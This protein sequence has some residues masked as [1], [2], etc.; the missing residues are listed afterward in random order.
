MST[1]PD[2]QFDGHT[3]TWVVP[4]AEG[5]NQQLSDASKWKTTSDVLGAADR[6]AAKGALK[7]TPDNWKPDTN[8]LARSY[9]N[10]TFTFT[11]VDPKPVKVEDLP[12]QSYIQ[13][14]MQPQLSLTN[15]TAKKPGKLREL[16]TA[17]QDPLWE[18]TGQ[19]VLLAAL[20]SEPARLSGTVLT[21]SAF[22]FCALFVAF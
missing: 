9:A 4:A 7:P 18:Y 21:A 2:T 12:I 17:S 13:M 1:L 3:W 20:T 19:N 10:K 5:T 14:Q 11:M 22:A 15:T 6:K 16:Q 8:P